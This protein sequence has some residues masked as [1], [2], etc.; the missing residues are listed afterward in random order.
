MQVHPS[1]LR[2]EETS[3]EVGGETTKSLS[4]DEEIKGLL[5][6]RQLEPSLGFLRPA[7][8]FHEHNT[9]LASTMDTRMLPFIRELG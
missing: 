9:A 7:C 2:K 4:V 5:N 3:W 6:E 8:N 1:A